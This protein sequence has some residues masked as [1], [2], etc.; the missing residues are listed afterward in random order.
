MWLTLW[1]PVAHTGGFFV[2]YLRCR[3]QAGPKVRVALA[4]APPR[5]ANPLGAGQGFRGLESSSCPGPPPGRQPLRRRAGQ[6]Q[7]LRLSAFT[8]PPVPEAGRWR[9]ATRV[10]FSAGLVWTY[11]ARYESSHLRAHV[12][13]PAETHRRK[14][15]AGYL[16]ACSRGN[17]RTENAGRAY[18][19]LQGSCFGCCSI[20]LVR[21]ACALESPL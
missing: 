1:D 4:L 11:A 7:V 12:T 2:P 19:R 20:L 13:F 14:G 8:F 21:V 18:R 9:A 3:L 5:V 16:P 17:Q 10:R 6:S 15:H